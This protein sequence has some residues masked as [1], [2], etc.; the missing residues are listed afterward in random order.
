MTEDDYD[1]DIKNYRWSGYFHFSASVRLPSDMLLGDD[2]ALFQ[3]GWKIHG[4][5]NEKKRIE[6]N[7]E[8]RAKKFVKLLS[9]F[10]NHISSLNTFELVPLYGRAEYE[11]D[12]DSNP[13]DRYSYYVSPL[14][15][16]S[17]EPKRK[18][19]SCT[20]EPSI[21][22]FSSKAKEAVRPDL[23]ITDY[24]CPVCDFVIDR[25][26]DRERQVRNRGSYEEDYKLQR[27]FAHLMAVRRSGLFIPSSAIRRHHLFLP[28]G[29]IKPK[30]KSS[31]RTFIIVPYLV[32]HRDPDAIQVRRNFSLNA[33]VV[34]GNQ[35]GDRP[36]RFSTK[37]L[38]GFLSIM[39]RNN[40]FLFE[41]E[42]ELSQYL[43]VLEGPHDRGLMRAM[44]S[45]LPMFNVD[46]NTLADEPTFDKDKWIRD[47]DAV[48]T[49]HLATSPVAVAALLDNKR[50]VIDKI[51]RKDV[52]TWLGG[53]APTSLKPIEKLLGYFYFFGRKQ[54]LQSLWIESITNERPETNVIGLLFYGQSGPA[55][56]TARILF[57]TGPADE[58]F[59]A[60]SLHWTLA[61]SAVMGASL[62]SAEQ[63]FQA[64][65]HELVKEDSRSRG[66]DGDLSAFLDVSREFVVDLEELY[67]LDNTMRDYKEEYDAIKKK[68][69]M[70]QRYQN[71]K[72]E[73]DELGQ[74]LTVKGTIAREK[75]M[76]KMTKQ[77]FALTKYVLVASAALGVLTAVILGFTIVM[78]ESNAKAANVAYGVPMGIVFIIFVSWG[79]LSWC[80][81]RRKALVANG[82]LPKNS[83]RMDVLC[84]VLARLSRKRK[85]RVAGR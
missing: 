31:K 84:Y 51:S 32:F 47:C 28:P 52:M 79:L 77:I 3:S 10:S 43:G 45:C 9:D 42:S 59:P 8:E 62:S 72:T 18:Q 53:G 58:A 60:T 75:Q 26:K 27:F 76:S 16:V 54:T 12:T 34:V 82:A 48:L 15:T 21:V 24:K 68:S 61:T 25:P 41:K 14:S 22:T 19:P 56:R 39:G 81:R 74:Q 2:C 55:V 20:H 71:L 50:K 13:T 7:F 63:M 70:N 1:I 83:S 37:E 44:F 17:R 23:V 49:N 29:R 67:N 33:F 65:H 11:S 40:T 4:G 46:R 30:G 78:A 73:M 64:F 5:K 35:K 38:S 66:D 85:E 6:R 69:G 36:A 57:V 80:N